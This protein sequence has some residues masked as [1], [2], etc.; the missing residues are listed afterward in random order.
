MGMIWSLF[1]LFYFDILYFFMALF[2][3]NHE[4]IFL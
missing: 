3:I 4:S 2:F 1:K